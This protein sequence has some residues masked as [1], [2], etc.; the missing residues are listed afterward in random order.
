M[1]S[2]NIV[3]LLFIY[4]VNDYI[5][6]LFTDFEVKLML[7]YIELCSLYIDFTLRVYVLMPSEL[8]RV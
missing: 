6:D 8:T 1:I 5:N 2:M 3:N 7:S 4:Y